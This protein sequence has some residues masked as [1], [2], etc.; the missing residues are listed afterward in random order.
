MTS[1]LFP[2]LGHYSLAADRLQQA[3]DLIGCSDLADAI[4]S[5]KAAVEA[6]HQL[7]LEDQVSSYSA[8]A[9]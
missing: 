8:W 9:D 4:L 7:A 5:L 3:A 6:D 2:D 1:P